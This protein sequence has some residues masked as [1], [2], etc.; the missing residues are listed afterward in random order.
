MAFPTRNS[1]SYAFPN[2]N[3]GNLLKEDGDMLLAESGDGI[4]LENP[5]NNPNFSQRHTPPSITLDE[6]TMSFDD[7][8]FAFDDAVGYVF[9]QRH[10]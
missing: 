3:V 10:A 9:P 2:V 7:A 5:V 4:L 6:A 1:S 8:L